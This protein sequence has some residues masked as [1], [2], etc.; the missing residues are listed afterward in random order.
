MLN[1]FQRLHQNNTISFI[2]VVSQAK[3]EK[4]DN[5]HVLW[6]GTEQTFFLCMV[7]SFPGNEQAMVFRVLIQSPIDVEIRARLR[8]R[9]VSLELTLLACLNQWGNITRS[10]PNWEH[11][12]RGHQAAQ[13]PQGYKT[14][15][16][17]A[18]QGVLFCRHGIN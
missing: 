2:W 5:E 11:G 15:C 6:S 17:S 12:A 7:S 16:V 8:R 4:D 14:C 13:L 10:Q 18:P 1:P 9:Q 3:A